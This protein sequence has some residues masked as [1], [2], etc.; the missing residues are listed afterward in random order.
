MVL[1]KNNSKVINMFSDASGVGFGATYGSYWIQGTWSG[2]WKM[3]H[4]TIRET[5]H[6]LA[7]IYTFGHKLRNSSIRFYCDNAA[8]AETINK[9]SSKDS[10][11][12]NSIRPLV[13]KPLE[14]N[15]HFFAEHILQGLKTFYLTQFHVFRM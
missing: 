10:N 15:I 13:L 1:E 14:L 9:Q 11:I 4:I 12:M 3:Y 6:I 5:Y 2:S 8:V 7:L